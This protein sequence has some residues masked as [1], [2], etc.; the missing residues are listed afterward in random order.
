MISLSQH[1]HTVCHKLRHEL[2]PEGAVHFVMREQ[3]LVL[4]SLDWALTATLSIS[5]AATK[6]QNT[7][8]FPDVITFSN[9]CSTAW[10]NNLG[11]LL[12]SFLL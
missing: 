1:E 11:N 4:H 2:F 3:S 5:P 10:L 9:M 12:I 8:F 7:C 6:V